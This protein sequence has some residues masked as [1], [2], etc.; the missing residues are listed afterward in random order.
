MPDKKLVDYLLY[1]MKFGF[2]IGFDRKVTTCKAT[3]NMKSALDNPEPAL[4][5]LQARRIIG[6]LSPSAFPSESFRRNSKA[7]P[8]REMAAHP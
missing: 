5:F 6:P 2:R 3:K 7:I 1:G 8:A 4:K